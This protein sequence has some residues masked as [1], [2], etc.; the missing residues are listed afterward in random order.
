MVPEIQIIGGGLAGCEAAWQAAAMGVR[1]AL[2]EMRPTRATLVH[3]T[4]RLAE[5]VCSNSFRGDKLDNAVG[6]LK[7]EMRRLGSLVMRAAD[8]T[9]VPAGAALAVDR[10]RFAE[11]VSEAV[12]AHPMIT[13]RREERTAIPERRDGCPVVIATGPLT[14]APLS[15]SIARFVGRDHL[16][17]YDAISP[18]VLAESID[19]KRAFRASRWDR[20]LGGRPESGNVV[21]EAEPGNHV[22]PACG[23]DDGSGDYLNCPFTQDEY[24]AFFQALLHA[25]SATVHDFDKERFFEGCLPVEVMAHRGVDTLRFGPMKPV[26]L[27]DP[28]TGRRPYAVLQ[29]RQDNLAGD[30]FSLVGFQTQLKWGEQARVFRLV[31]G[32]EHAEFVRFGMVHRNTYING[33]TVLR[34]TWQTRARDDLF[35]AGQVSGVEGYVESAASGLIAGTNA[36]RLAQGLAPSAPPRTTAVGALAYYVSHAD[37]SGYQPT[38]ITFGIIAPLDAPP[39]DRGRRNELIAARALDD[40]DAW[41]RRGGLPKPCE[42]RRA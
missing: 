36:A 30:H 42:A 12:S 16:Y 35:F 4:D 9:R 34:D 41:I 22:V 13:V 2:Y 37:S 27:I 39:R 11:A 14:S 31:P 25:E 10:D 26:G 32:L 1:V 6:L 20:S 21:S 28:R 8:A 7:E 5:L 17:F 24:D 33:P 18:I 19:R 40:L 38:N 29:L 3:R 15:A 23:V